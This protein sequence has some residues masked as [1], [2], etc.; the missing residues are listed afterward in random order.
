MSSRVQTLIRG[1][2]KVVSGNSLCSYKTHCC[3]SPI[4]WV[5]CSFPWVVATL[6]RLRMRLINTAELTSR[7]G[8]GTV[9]TE[10]WGSSGPSS[11]EWKR[12]ISILLP[13]KVEVFLYL[14]YQFIVTSYPQRKRKESANSRRIGSLGAVEK[15]LPHPSSRLPLPKHPKSVPCFYFFFL[16]NKQTKSLDLWWT[17][18][19]AHKNWEMRQT[20]II[21]LFPWPDSVWGQCSVHLVLQE[22]GYLRKAWGVKKKVRMTGLGHGMKTTHTAVLHFY[23][24]NLRERSLSP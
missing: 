4:F 5:E 7:K 2:V 22:V 23:T 18:L 15:P 9:R 8:V 12:C 14:S 16:L 3:C 6:L 20:A 1:Q 11:A 17:K 21:S 19:S 10:C 24:G 13:G